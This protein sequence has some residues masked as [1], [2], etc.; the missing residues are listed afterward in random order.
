ME[1]HTGGTMQTFLYVHWRGV[2][3]PSEDA[4]TCMMWGVGIGQ[5]CGTH[6]LKVFP[7][8]TAREST[9][10]SDQIISSYDKMIFSVPVSII[11]REMG[12]CYS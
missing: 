12:K 7:S 3:R 5:Q 1:P 10:S 6:L 2:K 9:F 8:L 4:L 11:L